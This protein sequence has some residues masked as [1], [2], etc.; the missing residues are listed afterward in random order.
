MIIAVDGPAASGKGTLA[1]A[2][3]AHYGLRFLDTG[4]LY[5]MVALS[6]LRQDADAKDETIAT[7]AA[8]EL[9]PQGF[10]DDELRTAEVGAA[11]STVAAIPGVRDAILDLQRN[12]AHQPPGA[13]LDGRDIGTVVCPEAEVKLFVTASL[14]VRAERRFKELA[15]RGEEASYDRVF[16]DLA[17]RD[18]RD[19]NR[20]ISPL[21]KAQD[22]H[23]LDTSDLS[24]ETAFR[25]ACA[26][27]DAALEN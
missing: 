2:L 27:V 14:K 18:A 3:A 22:A 6:V 11:A 26:L 12:F 23:L 5:R 25:Q 1:R 16:D 21:K 24:I 8:E 10:S 15:Q 7:K 19:A 4:S 13:V 9:D 20:T 17:E